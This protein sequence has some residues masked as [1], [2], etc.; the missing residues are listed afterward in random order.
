MSWCS[1]LALLPVPTELPCNCNLEEVTAKGSSHP[2][3]GSH[4][5]RSVVANSGEMYEAPFP[6]DVKQQTLIEI[7][8]PW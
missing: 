1:K 3:S 5:P 8:D 6:T 7:W 4:V 2:D